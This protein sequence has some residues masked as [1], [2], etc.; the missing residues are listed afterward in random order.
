MWMCVDLVR[1]FVMFFLG[2]RFVLSASFP[3]CCLKPCVLVFIID[4]QKGENELGVQCWT[5]T[6]KEEEKQCDLIIRR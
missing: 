3:L 5:S 1:V 6:R 2:F 4:P